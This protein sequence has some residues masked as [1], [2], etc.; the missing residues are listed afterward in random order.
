MARTTTTMK[1][2]LVAGLA[3]SIALPGLAAAQIGGFDVEIPKDDKA[4]KPKKQQIVDVR[5]DS[6]WKGPKTIEDA[7]RLVKEGGE[8]VVHPGVY[9]PEFIKLKKSV[10]IRGIRDEYGEAPTLVADG[11]CLSVASDKV[12]ARVTDVV[13]KASDATCITVSKG[14]LELAD[15]EVQG[16]NAGYY[17]PAAYG[18]SSVFN[19]AAAS[20]PKSALVSIRGGRV[21]IENTKLVGGEAGV[22]IKPSTTGN[23]FDQVSLRDSTVSQMT[24]AGVVMVGKVDAMLSGNSIMQN[25]QGGIVYNASG[26]ARMVGNIVSNNTHL[27]VFIE[28]NDLG[29]V[30][31]EGNQIHDNTSNGIVVRAGTTILAGNQIGDHA[32]C[33]V[34][35]DAL[36]DGSSAHLAKPP[37]NLL[38]DAQGVNAFVMKG[39]CDKGKPEK[40]KSRRWGL[41]S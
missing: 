18:H 36:N 2:A 28:G 31:V 10:S 1:K 11:G 25:G 35:K 27:G 8:I 7:M 40:K 13:F 38:A 21:S 39:G 16:R 6:S 19:S 24:G 29:A 26:H 5:L 4:A 41:F 30:A 33:R 9:S 34:K 32:E 12:A 23:A 3:A 37:I 20:S 17:R 15:A 22:F 14:Q